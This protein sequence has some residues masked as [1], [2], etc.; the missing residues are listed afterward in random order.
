MGNKYQSLL[1]EWCDA[2]LETQITDA[3]NEFF[4]AFYC[5]SCSFPHGRADNAIYPFV[6][7]Y[8]LTNDKKYLDGAFRLLVFRKKLTHPDGS[9]QNDFSSSWQG[10]TAFSAIG[11]LK[12]LLY[13]R[14]II[15]L[16]LKQEIEFCAIS[17]SHWVY[18][19]MVIGFPAYINYYCAASL[20]NALY[21]T[22][23]H[24]KAYKTR[25]KE[26][27]DYCLS[28][29]TQN[30][31]FYGEGKPH[32]S[33]SPKGCFAVDIGY[34]VEESLPCLV[35]AAFLLNDK[36]AIDIL[37][38]NTLK[39]LD[40]M[41]P[42]GG[43]D[44]SFGVR[45]NKWTYYGSRTSD[46]CIGLFTMLSREN[47]LFR[48]ASER[49]Y[50][51]LKKCTVNGLL[52][53]GLH[54]FEN[55][56]MPCVHHTFCHASALA[57]ALHEGIKEPEERLLLPAEKQSNHVKFYPEINTYKIH[58]EDYI[59]T[60][61]GYD[62]INQHYKN[63][64][65]HASGGTLSLLYKNGSGV[66]IAGSVYEYKPT[67]PNN[68]QLPIGEKYHASLL[69]RAEY[70]KEG[71][72]YATCLDRSPRIIIKEEKNSVTAYVKAKFCTK[73]GSDENVYADFSYHFQKTGIT[74]SIKK[75]NEETRFILPIVKNSGSVITK[76]K[77]QKRSI[78]FL[79]GGFAAEEYSFLLD[80]NITLTLV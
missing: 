11:L 64:A 14:D 12:T 80:Q 21:A 23:Y 73:N 58:I 25:A 43:W 47:P 50:E 48:E 39:L 77:A 40:F 10:I 1:I 33:T 71:V 42:D 66:I 41:L 61:T 37:S 62:Y 3:E 45:N 76:H 17:A 51:I 65:A 70:Q 9:V 60:L 69:P 13:F 59:A 57:D 15:P 26:L 36:N 74:L 16:S 56:Q 53:G 20:V 54:Y 67:E 30:G 19:N 18:D 6:Y 79:T 38:K 46:G 44:N 72:T 8:A 78:F 4:G 35:H 5:N 34:E 68:M 24:N 22:L 29:F 55:G 7:S 75:V 52:Y 2:L 49:T 32:N 28:Y 63:G 31:L 27:L